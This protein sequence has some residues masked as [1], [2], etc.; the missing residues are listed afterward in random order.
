[1]ISYDNGTAHNASLVYDGEGYAI[2]LG[3]YAP[4]VNV[5]FSI[6]LNDVLG[7]SFVINGGTYHILSNATSTTSTSPT[8]TGMLPLIVGITAV[9]GIL[10]VAVVFAVLRKKT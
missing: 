10:A 5:T 4:G 7:N 6:L 8:E 9:G 1:M 2:T 3:P